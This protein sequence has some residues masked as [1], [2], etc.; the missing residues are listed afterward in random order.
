MRNDSLLERAHR[1]K[2]ERNIQTMPAPPHHDLP[3]ADWPIDADLVRALLADQH[4]DLAALPLHHVASGFDN[5]TFR[6]GDMLAVR[7]PRRVVSAPLA[8]HEQTWL[9]QVAPGLPVAVP[10][11]LRVGQASAGYPSAWSV[12]PWLSGEPA[13]TAS[14]ADHARLALALAD[15][16]AALHRPAPEHA[17]INPYR[18]VA[19]VQRQ[20]VAEERMARLDIRGL[21][22]PAVRGAWDTALALAPLGVPVW[23][24]GDLHPLNLL[25]DDGRLSAVID[26][27][28]M[29]QGDAAC[30]LA[31]L[32]MLFDD[33]ASR[34]A[35]MQAYSLARTQADPAPRPTVSAE[36][37]AR[38]RGWA[39]LFGVFL[40]AIGDPARSRLA[41]IGLN[42]LR[43]I[44]E[45]G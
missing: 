40:A 4:P 11:P 23:I 37:W 1:Y 43:R 9:P 22:T 6:L 21:V 13:D 25:V 18:G 2:Q 7:L 15:F 27:G 5:E 17:P 16:M 24:H 36:T 10:L 42:T 38:A 20:A 41:A 14:P 12:L 8:L 35:A 30:D 19:L 31:C 26:W 28:D 45:E 34:A 44:D 39:V 33:A 32:W 3:P 29:A